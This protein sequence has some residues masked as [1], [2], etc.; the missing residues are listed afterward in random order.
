MKPFFNSLK[1]VE[2]WLLIALMVAFTIIAFLQ[3]V[4]RLVVRSPLAWSEEATRYLFIW[5]MFLGSAVVM[6]NSGH[7][8]IDFVVKLF[9]PKIEKVFNYFAY[10]CI[11]VFSYI[12]VKYGFVLVNQTKTQMTPALKL[13]MSWVYLII[14]ASGILMLLHL[15]EIIYDNIKKNNLNKSL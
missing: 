6:A 5:S 2:Y 4:F 15:V 7:F 14:P 1:K 12:L 13:N 11:A 8:N 9:P 10:L 3:V